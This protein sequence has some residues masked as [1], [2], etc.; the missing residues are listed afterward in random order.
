MPDKPNQAQRRLPDSPA[1]PSDPPAGGI[2]RRTVLRGGAA[3]GAAALGGAAL[4]IG[5]QASQ[6]LKPRVEVPHVHG[7]GGTGPVRDIQPG[8]FDP[9]AAR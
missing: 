8:G 2:S 9:T 4:G 1:G 5:N 7:A 6:A 3:L